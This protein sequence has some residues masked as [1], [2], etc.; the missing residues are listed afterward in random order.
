MA[1]RMR[2]VIIGNGLQ[3]TVKTGIHLR[4]RKMEISLKHD[5]SELVPCPKCG[6][7]FDPTPKWN[8][9]ARKYCSRSC[10]GSIGG[11]SKSDNRGRHKEITCSRYYDGFDDKEWS[12]FVSRCNV[13]FAK[14]MERKGLVMTYNGRVV[15]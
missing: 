11:S 9:I 12:R 15:E 1:Y 3:Q 13:N 8:K 5:M 6:S 7:L 10:A 4:Y 14:W 2:F